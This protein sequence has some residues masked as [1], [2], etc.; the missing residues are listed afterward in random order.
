[1]FDEVKDI[2][3]TVIYSKNHQ[4]GYYFEAKDKKHFQSLL[5]NEIK[6]LNDGET[7][8]I[9]RKMVSKKFLDC[10]AAPE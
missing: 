6:L 10:C 1:M 9:K 8:E 4:G 5:R 7:I 3:V 2:P